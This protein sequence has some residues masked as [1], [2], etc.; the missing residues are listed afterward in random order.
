MQV[1]VVLRE[2]E[3]VE[4]DE[5]VV[6]VW[7]PRRAK[8]GVSVS[9]HCRHVTPIEVDFATGSAWSF[10]SGRPPPVLGGAEPVDAA[11]GYAQLQ[12]DLFSDVIVGVNR[13]VQPFRVETERI[14]HQLQSPLAG[15]FLEVVPEAEVAQH[16]EEGHVCGVADLFYV[17]GSKAF[18]DRCDAFPGRLE[19]AGKVRLERRHACVCEQECRVSG[20]DERCRREAEVAA[21]L[22]EPEKRLSQILCGY[23][24][25]LF[26]VVTRRNSRG[27]CQCFLSAAEV[28]R[29]ARAR[30][31]RIWFWAQ[32]QFRNRGTDVS[33]SK[34]N[35]PVL[36]SP[37]REYAARSS[38][39]YS[40]AVSCTRR[41]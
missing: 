32:F 18:L 26:L 35:V 22:E 34:A 19:F 38:S 24:V 23:H 29:I 25:C 5:V 13:Y 28:A 16:L 2:Y 30:P 37:K 33:K 20:G 17:G 41:C 39:P 14:G 31:Y 12:P 21:V 6:Q 15:L 1:S 36:R 3:V 8:C 40:T 11:C 27:H 10:S 9:R 4:L 7:S